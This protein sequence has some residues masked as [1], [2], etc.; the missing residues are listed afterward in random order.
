[1]WHGIVYS[2]V[3][4][5]FSYSQSANDKVASHMYFIWT[6]YILFSVRVFHLFVSLFRW[7]LFSFSTFQ[8][9]SLFVYFGFGFFF[10]GFY[11]FCVFCVCFVYFSFSIKFQPFRSE[12]WHTNQGRITR[13]KI[14]ETLLTQ[15]TMLK[16]DDRRI[17]KTKQQSCK[18]ANSTLLH[19]WVCGNK[20]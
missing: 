5:H 8:F 18:E 14:V 1:M 12:P 7:I 20:I 3:S 15:Q 19:S 4:E 17:S 11:L 6:W 2:M 16:I 9:T 13:K 10:F